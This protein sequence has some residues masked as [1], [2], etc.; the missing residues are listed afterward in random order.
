[1]LI[2]P[3]NEFE[4]RKNFSKVISLRI[5]KEGMNRVRCFEEQHLRYFTELMMFV[6]IT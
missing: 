2:C 5:N 6:Y 4:N 3:L 1:M